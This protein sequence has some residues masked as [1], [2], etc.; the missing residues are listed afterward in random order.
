MDM[1]M[2]KVLGSAVLA[3]TVLLV[4][5]GDDKQAAEEKPAAP[6]V[7]QSLMEPSA[8]DKLKQEAGETLEAAGEVMKEAEQDVRDAASDMTDK[9]AEMG[10]EIKQDAADAYQ[11]AEESVSELGD[12]A[13]DTAAELE[14]D[15]RAKLDSMQQDAQQDAESETQQ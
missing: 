4:G 13:A 12:K 14:Q 5:C 10:E 2:V 15:A 6:A 11:Q 7:E 9:A 1:S 3:S 8:T